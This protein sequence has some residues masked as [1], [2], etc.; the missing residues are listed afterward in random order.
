[1]KTT[2]ALLLRVFRR[3]SGRGIN[4]LPMAPTA[5]KLP[6]Q[7]LP[8]SQR[9]ARPG[10]QHDMTVTFFFFPLPTFLKRDPTMPCFH[11]IVY[12]AVRGGRMER[13]SEFLADIQTATPN[14]TSQVH[15]IKKKTIKKEKARRRPY[16]HTSPSDALW[17]LTSWFREEKLFKM[18]QN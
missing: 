6:P 9:W 2:P 16:A 18:L 13:T 14:L 10:Q 15:Q 4:R 5:L 1:M 12:S 17:H 7:R 3:L 11:G 8:Q